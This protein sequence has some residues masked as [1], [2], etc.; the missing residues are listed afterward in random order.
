MNNDYMTQSEV[1]KALGISR[2]RVS[3]IESRALRKLR[4]SAKLRAF[5]DI[6][7]DWQ[8]YYGEEYEKVPTSDIIY[9]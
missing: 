4:R 3:Q 5:Y 1:A 8:E 6:V 2:S 9:R 7:D